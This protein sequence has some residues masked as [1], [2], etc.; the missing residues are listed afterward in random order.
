VLVVRHPALEAIESRL[1]GSVVSLGLQA[2]PPYHRGLPKGS[3]WQF[4]GDGLRRGPTD[5]PVLRGAPLDTLLQIADDGLQRLL[6]ACLLPAAEQSRWPPHQPGPG[7][8]GDRRPSWRW[9]PQV[10]G[11]PPG[12]HG[13]SQLL[14]AP[15]RRC[16]T[17]LESGC[18]IAAFS[19]VVDSILDDTRVGRYCSIGRAFAI[20]QHDH[21]TTWLSTHPFQFQYTNAIGFEAPGFVFGGLTAQAE[22]QA[23]R[24]RQFSAAAG[25]RRHTH[26]GHDVWIGARMFVRRG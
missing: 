3:G 14:R 22:P 23:A 25:C 18:R 5:G 17:C 15:L 26:I 11:R 10:P 1:P 24:W 2:L 13:S 9:P 21:P 4:G 7:G 20:G 16:G 19:Y 12:S 8:R 6:A